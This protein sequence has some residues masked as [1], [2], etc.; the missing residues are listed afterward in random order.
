MK[1]V[2]IYFCTICTIFTTLWNYVSPHVDQQVRHK[3]H[4]ILSCTSLL[5]LPLGVSLSESRRDWSSSISSLCRLQDFGAAES[6]WGVVVCVVCPLRW[7]T[8]N[9]VVFEVCRMWPEILFRTGN[10]WV[11]SN[12]AVII[13]Y[14]MLLSFIYTPPPVWSTFASSRLECLLLCEAIILWH[15]QCWGDSWLLPKTH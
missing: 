8:K 4:K 11:P 1:I 6:G 15:G 10:A 12:V 7:R 9:W 13:L 2:S 3:G 14:I 5:M